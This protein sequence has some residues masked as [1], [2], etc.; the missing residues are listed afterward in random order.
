MTGTHIA[1]FKILV[2]G[3]LPL[4]QEFLAISSVWDKWGTTAYVARGTT[5]TIDSQVVTIARGIVNRLAAARAAIDESAH[6]TWNVVENN[7][8]A[9]TDAW[10]AVATH[11]RSV[12]FIVKEIHMNEIFDAAFSESLHRGE[13]R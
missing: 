8:R 2:K 11:A 5:A 4:S 9:A 3:S 7:R 1:I 10:D 6:A 13:V 12:R